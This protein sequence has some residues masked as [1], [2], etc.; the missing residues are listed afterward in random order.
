[1]LLPAQTN[2]NKTIIGCYQIEKQTKLKA[3]SDE[4]AVVFRRKMTEGEKAINSKFSLSLPPS[5]LWRATYCPLE[6][7]RFC[8]RGLKRRTKSTAAPT[9]AP[10]IRHRRRS[11]TLPVRGRLCFTQ[12]FK[13]DKSRIKALKLNYTR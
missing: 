1:M 3:P 9:D 4:G 13:L 11:H 10:F 2:K 7:Y 6:V 8:L 12:F 5:R